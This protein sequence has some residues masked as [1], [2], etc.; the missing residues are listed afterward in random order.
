[1]GLIIILLSMLFTPGLVFAAPPEKV[2]PDK[3]A[4]YMIYQYPGV[5]LLIRI[6]TAGIEFESRVL[7]PE[8]SLVMASRIPN[9]RL[10]PVYQ[11]IEAVGEPR[12]LI[13]QVRPQEVS[14]RSR[15]NM[16]LVQLTG[17]DSNSAAQLAAFRLLSLAAESTQAN[18]TTTWAMKIYTLKR[19]AQ[20]F[21]QLGWE[22]LRLWSEYYAAHLVF[23]KLHDNLS[24]MEFARQVEAAASKA[25]IAIVEL[26]ALQLE[27]AALM[28]S[29]A[30]SSGQKAA[31]SF[32]EAHR[33]YQRA[34][35][36]ADGLGLQLER[37]RA[38]F[39]DGLSWEQQEN[40]NRALEQ[41]ELALSIAVAEGNAEL[42]NLARNKAAFVYEMQGSLSGA[43][44]ILDQAG[45]GG[46]DEPESERQA[47]SLFEK[48]RLLV[49]T[50]CFQKAVEAL[51]QSL[52]LQ[53]VTGSG[54]RTGPTNMLLG[55]SYYGMG[56]MEQAVTVLREAIKST[57]ASDNAGLLG[58]AFN[59][60]AAIGRFQGDAERM[61]GN[62]EQQA[63][64]LVSDYD[65]AKYI[66]EQSLDA[67]VVH[68]KRSA[69][70]SSLFNRSRQQAIKNGDR[71]LQH[72]SILYLCSLA[73]SNK[74]D[75][76]QACTDQLVRQSVDFL[77]AAG[78]PAYTLEAKW[79]WSKSLRAEGRLSQA[80][81]QM[82]QLVDGMRF[83]RSV[84]PGVLGAWYW[85]NREEIYA[86][87]MS[88]V[89]QRS[90][91]NDREFVDGRQTL[92]VLNRL[93]AIENPGGSLADSA[94]GPDGRDESGQIR[95]LL[96]K[97]QQ[98]PQHKATTT[99]VLEINE[100][101]RLAQDRFAATSETLDASGLDRLL[102]HLSAGSVLRATTFRTTGLMPW[103]G[104]IMVYSCW[105]CALHG[106][107]RRSW[108]ESGHQWVNRMV[109]R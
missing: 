9:R 97:N 47:K 107:S 35:I 18:D 101:L 5:A 55:Q 46:G 40:L 109:L 85:E 73:S 72:R 88:M 99:E 28:E 37:S 59:T 98:T 63:A 71:V 13:I 10:G 82:S 2:S 22:E 56:H 21:E 67:L 68:G 108:L 75:R 69:T 83:Y 51:T 25:G 36:M 41:Y 27:G 44:E 86:D 14:E 12:Q 103:S 3:P 65:Q 39:N 80:I 94:I 79:L 34:A 89:L 54:S 4:E 96:A 90:A 42:E 7:G 61:T 84:L 76:E 49:E 32:D 92:V 106:I 91:V 78:I 38:I 16:E 29:A 31:V 74:A 105:N 62:R 95:S 24:T 20:A 15:I 57:P 81:K 66:F 6:D 50:G 53:R 87:Y 30:A 17:K 19:A 26:A 100:W 48:G 58:E 93:R 33:I 43:I 70:V 64:F 45:G 104:V 77:L 8:Q 1:M 60:L 52:Q 102:K 23:F 11:L